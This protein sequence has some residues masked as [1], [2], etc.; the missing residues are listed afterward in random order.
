MAATGI[1]NDLCFQVP[2]KIHFSIEDVVP[3]GTPLLR[4]VPRQLHQILTP[5]MH[6][7]LHLENAH[8]H[9]T[10]LMPCAMRAAIAV[11]RILEAMQ[12]SRLKLALH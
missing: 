5:A 4:L 6:S 10:K 9:Q 12:D 7:H 1:V 11:L 8:H 3:A 2:C